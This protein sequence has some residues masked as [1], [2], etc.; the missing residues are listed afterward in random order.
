[1]KA[2]MRMVELLAILS[3]AILIIGAAV[4]H[5]DH[6]TAQRSRQSDL[7]TPAVPSSSIAWS[8]VASRP[9]AAAE[10]NPEHLTLPSEAS[11]QTAQ[12]VVDLATRWA[13]QVGATHPQVEE[14]RLE[15]IK[16]AMETTLVRLG[17]PTSLAMVGQ[18]GVDP[19]KP[20]WRILLGGDNFALPSCPAPVSTATPD[21]C[22]TSTSIEFVI[23]PMSG[24]AIQDTYGVQPVATATP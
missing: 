9:T 14:I 17:Q 11:I 5:G 4:L 2:P 19:M 16:T 22:G 18:P 10:V 21:N 8:N 12:Q 15:T 7:P 24:D 3:A 13:T 23:D 6:G 1:M 20:V